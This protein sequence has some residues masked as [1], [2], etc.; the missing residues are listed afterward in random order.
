MLRIGTGGKWRPPGSIPRWG[1]VFAAL[2]VLSAARFECRLGRAVVG[3]D[4]A[5]SPASVV[6]FPSAVVLPPGGLAPLEGEVIDSFGRRASAP[7]VWS[8]LDPAV[9]SVAPRRGPR[10]VVEARAPGETL[11]TATHR[12]GL[13]DTVDVAVT[14]EGG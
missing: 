4:P 2:L 5:L 3:S 14:G 10:T 1:T 12:S 7:L 8:S 9:A 13:A 11:V 6:V